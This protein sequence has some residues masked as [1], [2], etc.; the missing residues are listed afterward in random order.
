MTAVRTLLFRCH[1]REQSFCSTRR[2]IWLKRMACF[3]FLRTVLSI[4]RK[5]SCKGTALTFMIDFYGLVFKLP[6]EPDLGEIHPDA[7]L[8]NTPPC[9]LKNKFS[10]VFTRFSVFIFI[11]PF[12]HFSFF[13]SSLFKALV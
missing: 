9:P 1:C 2:L 3:A 6:I 7:N 13:I 8:Y 5:S 11:F 12:F 10:G 4:F